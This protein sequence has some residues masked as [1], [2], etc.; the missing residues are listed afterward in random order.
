MVQIKSLKCFQCEK[1][2]SPDSNLF[3]CPDCQSGLNAIYDYD[4]IQTSI[5]GNAII[6]GEFRRIEAY[7]WKY[8]PFY[9]INDVTK[10]VSMNEGGTPL[11]ESKKIAKE[12]GCTHLYFKYEGANPTG[13][14]KDRGS[15]IEITNAIEKNAKSVIC[16]ST[17]NM[18]ASVAAYA[19]MAGIDCTILIPENIPTAKLAQII[20]YG[21]KLIQVKTNSYHTVQRL[22]EQ[23]ASQFNYFL[24]GDYINRTEGEK[25]VG[26]ELIDQLDWKPPDFVFC[27]IGTGTLIWAIWKAFL[28]F[29]NVKLI[30]KLPKI[31]GVQAEGC[32]P[33]IHAFKNNTLKI[34]PIENPKTIA[35]AIAAPDPITGNGALLA[36]KNSKGYGVTVSDE[37]IIQARSKLARIGLYAELS[38]AVSLAGLIKMHADF[39]D[40]L[41]Y[42]DI[43]CVITGHG[44][45][46]ALTGFD[47]EKRQ[48]EPDINAL[49]EVISPP[50]KIRH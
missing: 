44:L 16:A 12:V 4:E 21:A 47:M 10:I 40:E 46:D 22:S 13:S 32:A 5:L 36:I 19:A 34:T 41:K 50:G 42:E 29:K 26:F 49:K 6:R 39:K 37:E 28:E 20:A 1:S 18:G 45:K 9:P 11:I 3:R 23:A 15:T 35:S 14:F 38:G 8:Y 2:F 30:G 33:V 43:V 7:H 48:I 24:L 25:S 17:G 27:P 31:V